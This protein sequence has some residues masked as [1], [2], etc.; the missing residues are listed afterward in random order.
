MTREQNTQT[1]LSKLRENPGDLEKLLWTGTKT[2]EKLV[3][4]SS[5]QKYDGILPCINLYIK[6]YL[7]SQTCRRPIHQPIENT[8]MSVKF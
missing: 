8:V 7:S 1:L 3:G 4:F 2:V 6:M 5:E